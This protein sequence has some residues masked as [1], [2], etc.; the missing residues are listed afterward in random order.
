MSR[1]LRMAEAIPSDLE[2]TAFPQRYWGVAR[3]WVQMP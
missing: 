3:F 1:S 2:S